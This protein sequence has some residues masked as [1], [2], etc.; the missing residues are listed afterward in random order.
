ML[1]LRNPLIC[2][3]ILNE[4][5]ENPVFTIAGIRP[6]TL[7]ELESR[8]LMPPFNSKSGIVEYGQFDKGKLRNPIKVS[9]KYGSL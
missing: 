6:P 8:R 7:I 1:T 3:V 4:I 9:E 5:C 2:S